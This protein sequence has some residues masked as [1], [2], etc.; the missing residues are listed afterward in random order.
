MPATKFRCPDGVVVGIGDCLVNCRMGRRCLTLPTLITI[1]ASERP[2]DGKPSTTRLLN[3][4]MLEYL[5]VTKEYTINPKDRAFS[6]LGNQHHEKLA[7]L[8]GD[9]LSEQRQGNTITGTPDI[10]EPDSLIPGSYVLTDY[11][12]YGS[13]RV[14]KVLGIVKSKVKSTTERY[15]KAGAWGKVGDFKSTTNFTMVPET[16]DIHNEQLQ[17]NHYK[18]LLQDAGYPI[19]HMQ[20]QITVRDGGIKAAQDR[21]VTDSMY[22]VTIPPLDDTFIREYFNNR[23][24]ML[25][26]F[27]DGSVNPYPCNPD[28]SW[29]FRRCKDYC[30]VAE[31]CPQGKQVL[32]GVLKVG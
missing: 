1:A 25:N 23:K 26:S 3:G 10:I 29:N 19:S 12:T 20:L 4:P 17:L 5:K 31:F 13:Y 7:Q 21:G 32:S 27:L 2:Y 28:E 30:E 9:W 8:T 18:L 15:V 14:S 11:K 16:A 22:L 24:D 6:L